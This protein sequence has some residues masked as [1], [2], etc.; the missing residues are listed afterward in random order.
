MIP[1]GKKTKWNHL[2]IKFQY[3]WTFW[4][5]LDNQ[6][7]HRPPPLYILSPWLAIPLFLIAGLHIRAKIFRFPDRRPTRVKKILGCPTEFRPDPKLPENPKVARKPESGRV[8]VIFRARKSELSEGF[9]IFFFEFLTQIFP[10]SRPSLVHLITKRY[11]WSK[12][13]LKTFFDRFCRNFSIFKH[14]LNASEWH[15]S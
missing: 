8:R 4:Q 11:F 9:R 10:F 5:W 2:I 7:Y 3:C 6:Q 13:Q 14:F 12:Q 15:L 1:M